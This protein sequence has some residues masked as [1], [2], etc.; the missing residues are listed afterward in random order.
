MPAGRALG[1]RDLGV[2]RGA[3]ASAWLAFCWSGKSDGGNV[4]RSKPQGGD[5][6][7]RLSATDPADCQPPAPPALPP[8]KRQAAKGSSSSGGA[9]SFQLVLCLAV[10]PPCGQPGTWP[11]VPTWLGAP[12]PVCTPVLYR[13]PEVPHEQL[14]A[15]TPLLP[16]PRRQGCRPAPESKPIVRWQPN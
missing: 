15:V 11:N 1:Q 7:P 13:V 3:R 14:P 9:G 6:L 2:P 5:T 12:S 10:P 4:E 8:P 16:G